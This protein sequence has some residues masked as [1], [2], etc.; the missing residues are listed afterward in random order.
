VKPVSASLA[1]T[2]AVSVEAR[3]A[4][5]SASR[6]GVGGPGGARGADV[7]LP[8]RRLGVDSLGVA[9]TVVDEEAL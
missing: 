4:S 2:S 5:R 1:R 9:D 6:V 3:C 8:G 7:H